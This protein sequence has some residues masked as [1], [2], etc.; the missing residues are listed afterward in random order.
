M[1]QDGRKKGK[2]RTKWQKRA[3]L[4]VWVSR[5]M[6]AAVD[7][8]ARQSNLARSEFLRSALEEKT[9]HRGT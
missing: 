2:Q 6:A 3:F 8:A 5:A 4:G 1:G 7:K 9:R